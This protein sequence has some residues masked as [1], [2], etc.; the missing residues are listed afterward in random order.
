MDLTTEAIVRANVEEAL[1]RAVAHGS[2]ETMIPVGVLRRLWR[3]Y[4]DRGEALE[5]FAM[6]ADS[7]HHQ[8]S[9]DLPT[10]PTVLCGDLRAARA[11][12]TR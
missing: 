11:A 12:V 6:A 4:Q 8:Q 5:P 3:A 1:R 7:L 9:D 10:R 2:E